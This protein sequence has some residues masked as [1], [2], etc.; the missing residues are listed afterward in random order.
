M[1]TELIRLVVTLSLTAVGFLVGREVPGW[2]SS[3][4]VDPDAAIVLGTVIGAG[5]GYVLGGLLGRG[6]GRG[7]D[8]APQLVARTSGP[9]LFAGAFGMVAG[10]LVGVVAGLPLVLLTPTVV[11]WPLAALLVL[12]LAAFGGRIFAARAHDLLAAAGLRSRTATRRGPSGSGY[13]IDSAAAIDGRVLELARAG[14]LAG[15][16][17]VPEFVLDELQG[18]AD[19]GSKDR[20]RRGR[21]GLEVLEAL[22]DLPAVEMHTAETDLPGYEGVD[23]KLLALCQRSGGTLVST[24]SGL[25]RAAALRGVA[26]L[27][28]QAL[29]E[30]LRPQHLAG[31][32]M[33]LKIER[34]GT[35]PGQG[36]GH[37]DDGTMVVVEGGA[38]AVGQTVEVEVVNTLRTSL[39][40]MVFAKL[41]P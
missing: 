13:F 26:V 18:I 20:R 1:I 29:G 28:P 24:D 7:L 15:E 17:W 3:R 34:V 31:D 9:Q 25:T 16:V 38:G 11:G 36:V 21:R 39:G 40:R 37:L 6:V 8:R 32:R 22:R 10:L 30:A 27:N 33:A 2:F 12:V 5:L 41:E 35:E 4:V 19:S 23:A 14:V